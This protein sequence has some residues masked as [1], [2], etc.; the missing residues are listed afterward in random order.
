MSDFSQKSIESLISKAKDL[1]LTRLRVAD[2]DGEI[3]IELPRSVRTQAAAVEQPAASAPVPRDVLSQFVGYFR[4][5]VQPGSKVSKDTV[6]GIVESLGLPND[7]MAP[8][9]GTVCDFEVSDGEVVEY[10]TVIARI[11]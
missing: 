10:G 1:R 9:A 11:Q 7:I 6:V 4:A 3:S 5:S 8:A 2:G